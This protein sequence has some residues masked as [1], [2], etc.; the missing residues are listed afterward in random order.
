FDCILAEYNFKIFD[1]WGEKLFETSNPEEAWDGHFK[2]S[3][4]PIGVYIYRIDYQFEDL[5]K[6]TKFGN[7]TLIR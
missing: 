2:G 6:Q 3:V 4:S 5:E 7:V 1:R